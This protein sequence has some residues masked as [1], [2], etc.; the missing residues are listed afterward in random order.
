MGVNDYIKHALR[1]L[2]FNPNEIQLG[3]YVSIGVM[4]SEACFSANEERDIQGKDVV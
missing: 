4:R 3:V 2:W 1:N